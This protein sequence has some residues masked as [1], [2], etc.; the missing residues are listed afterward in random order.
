MRR[1]SVATAFVI[2]GGVVAA[3]GSG[4]TMATREQAPSKTSP[5]PT[6][7]PA[8]SSSVVVASTIPTSSVV[9]GSQATSDGEQ[10]GVRWSADVEGELLGLESAADRLYTVTM[11]GSTLEVVVFDRGDGSV[12]WDR[13][14]TDAAWPEPEYWGSATEYGLLLTFGAD[15]GGHLVLLDA[16]DG[17]IRWDESLTFP[18]YDVYEQVNDHVALFELSEGDLQFIDLDTTEQADA[19]DYF[20]NGWVVIGDEFARFEDN[21]LDESVPGTVVQEIIAE[22]V[23]ETVVVETVPW[24]VSVDDSTDTRPTPVDVEP[25]SLEVGWDPFDPQ[26]PTTPIELPAGTDEVDATDDGRL[27]V[28]TVGNELVGILDGEEVWRWTPDVAGIGYVEVLD[29]LIGVVEIVGDEYRGRVQYARIDD[30]R[31]EPFDVVPETFEV[32]DVRV[33]ADGNVA[34]VGV[35]DTTPGSSS[36]ERI[37]PAIVELDGRNSVHEMPAQLDGLSYVGAFGEYLYSASAYGDEQIVIYR[38]D[39][40]EPVTSIPYS[41]E[42]DLIDLGDE[43]IVYDAEQSTLSVYA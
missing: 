14:L 32:H 10:V 18:A 34:A 29:G 36:E 41:V 5:Q 35:F 43:I 30:N 37:T 2:V 28:A 13:T 12:L 23:V 4:A 21:D 42:S 8:R 6:T 17:E 15:A 3:V 11:N 40:F 16:D 7:L 33:D 19:G 31:I 27:I 1:V 24:T 22:G 26:A 9:E 20:S 39:S 25:R 38:G